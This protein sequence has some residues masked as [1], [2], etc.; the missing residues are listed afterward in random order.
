MHLFVYQT[1]NSHI[2]CPPPKKKNSIIKL[3]TLSADSRSIATAITVGRNTWIPRYIIKTV[4]PIS[5]MT[6]N[7]WG[8][9][10][11]LETKKKTIYKTKRAPNQLCWLTPGVGEGFIL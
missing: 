11:K 9:G 4:S 6:L 3:I 5:K 8:G 10:V 1:F 7:T 2:A